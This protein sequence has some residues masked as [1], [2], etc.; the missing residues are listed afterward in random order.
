MLQFSCPHYRRAMNWAIL[1]IFDQ[2]PFVFSREP[3]RPKLSFQQ[4][5]FDL[6]SVFVSPCTL[7][8]VIN[9]MRRQK[10]NNKGCCSRDD[11]DIPLRSSQR[12][13]STMIILFLHKQKAYDERTWIWLKTLLRKTD[14]ERTL[15]RRF[16]SEKNILE[17]H[18]DPALLGHNVM[19]SIQRSNWLKVDNDHG[20]IANKRV[21]RWG[22][23]ALSYKQTRLPTILKEKI[24]FYA[25]VL[26]LK[27]AYQVFSFT[28]CSGM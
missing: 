3:K 27:Q 7:P 14:D 5:H 17:L 18:Q 25:R 6:N 8:R 1:H 9:H 2:R 12:K 26:L 21:N 15:M 10:K 20:G 19:E 16:A 23:K 22:I 4:D 28:T 13:G 24:H 11:D